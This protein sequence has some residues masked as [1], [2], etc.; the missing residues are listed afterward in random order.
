[1]KKYLLPVFM[2]NYLLYS[3]AGNVSSAFVNSRN[4]DGLLWFFVFSCIG[5]SIFSGYRII[6]HLIR[7]KKNNPKSF[8]K[9]IIG[10]HY[11][12]NLIEKKAVFQIIDEFRKSDIIASEIPSN[13]LEK[14]TEFFISNLHRLKISD[15]EAEM[16]RKK[17]YPLVKNTP[18]EIEIKDENRLL[19]F[20]S[21][22]V[23]IDNRTIT[24]AFFGTNEYTIQKGTPIHICYT[25]NKAFISGNSR[26]TGIYS[27]DRI[28]IL[29]PDT[30][31]LSNERRYSR[32]P[33]SKVYGSLEVRNSED[34]IDFQLIDISVEGIRIKT[35]WRLKKNTIYKVAFKDKLGGVDYII[36]KIDCVICKTFIGERGYREYGMAFFYPNYETKRMLIN[37]IKKLGE[38]HTI[39]TPKITIK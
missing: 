38:F 7:S 18:V 12:I 9:N 19:V 8:I 34:I 5:V 24:L 13:I 15:S 4:T 29:H 31:S 23:H 2:S 25:I 37:Y 36:D 26:V 30:F 3:Q 11:E 22:V 6:L 16:L 28:V 10:K 35:Q 39:N 32:I 1:M 20:E 21:K 27:G 33:I 17:N 14:Y